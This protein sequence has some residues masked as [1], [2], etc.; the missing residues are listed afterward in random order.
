MCQGSSSRHYRRQGRFWFFYLSAVMGTGYNLSTGPV[1]LLFQN[2]TESVEFQERLIS[3]F[4]AAQNGSLVAKPL[5]LWKAMSPIHCNGPTWVKMARCSQCWISA[6]S[7]SFCKGGKR[8]TS[9]YE[10]PSPQ[11]SRCFLH[12]TPLCFRVA[13]LLNRCAASSAPKVFTYSKSTDGNRGPKPLP[14]QP[15]TS[16]GNPQRFL[17]S[18]CR[19]A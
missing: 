17:M 9:K 12:K 5:H 11:M 16:P 10:I 6:E 7:V 19:R 13:H 8:Q 14:K 3:V 1:C 18:P 4:S 15:F 2:S